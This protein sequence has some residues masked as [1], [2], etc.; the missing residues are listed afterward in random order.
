MP[1]VKLPTNRDRVGNNSV[2]GGIIFPLAAALPQGWSMG[3]MT[4][5][6]FIRDS[7]G[8]GRHPEFIH[9]I[10]FGHDLL[11]NLGG[12]FEFFSA[13][14]AEPGSSWIGTA[15]VGLTYGLTRDIQLDAGVNFGLTRAADD[16]NPFL[17]ISW[18]F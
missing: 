3:L 2:D 10:T 12:Y 18:R 6:D 11:G 17:G 4:E 13:V 14:S 8:R 9:S 15:D 16:I 5:V 7:A 1:F